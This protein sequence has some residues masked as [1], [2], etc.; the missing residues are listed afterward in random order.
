MRLPR[1][2]PLAVHFGDDETRFLQLRGRPGDWQVGFHAR[3]AGDAEELA[4]WAGEVPARGWKGRDAVVGLGPAQVES[5]IVPLD[6]EDE[7]GRDQLLAQAALTC[8][9]DEEGVRYRWLPLGRTPGTR[10]RE[11]LLLAVGESRVRR[12]GAA[13][14]AMGLR[15]VSLEPVVFGLARAIL[16]MQETTGAPWGFL[17]VGF[18]QAVFGV[19]HRGE[20][21]FLKPLQQNGRSFLDALSRKAEEL[22]EEPLPLVLEEATADH[23]Q[24][25][26]ATVW[27][28]ARLRRLSLDHA[29]ELLEAAERPADL[30][31]DEVRACLRHFHSR[32]KGAEVRGI[33]LSGFGATLP[34]VEEAVQRTLG[35]PVA[36][37]RPFS[38]LGILAPPEILDEEPLWAPVLGLAMRGYA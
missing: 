15:P 11:L 35:R 3:V 12:A 20:V 13:A 24:V 26:T 8:V 32:H 21:G 27:S 34:G 4:A 14:A 2:T 36:E 5:T 10:R 22:E 37:A 1:T 31:A 17:H 23:E 16:A 7:D 33:H 28:P 25:S 18:E 30:L 19:L 29:L 38:E 6:E 9:E